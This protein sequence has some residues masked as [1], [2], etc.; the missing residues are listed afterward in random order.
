MPAV[1]GS[2]S[3]PPQNST[4]SYNSS[5]GAAIASRS[6]SSGQTIA[7]SSCPLVDRSGATRKDVTVLK[8]EA[9]P[10]W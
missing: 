10:S 8:V 3:F 9:Q 4:S 2:F 6:I 7:R 5:C 1:M